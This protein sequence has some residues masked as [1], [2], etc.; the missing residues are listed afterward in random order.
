MFSSARGSGFWPGLWKRWSTWLALLLL[1]YFACNF[2]PI[3]I[4]IPVFG[5]MVVPGTLV[6]CLAIALSLEAFYG[7][8]PRAWALLPAT[9]IVG[10]YLVLAMQWHA[11]GELERTLAAQNSGPTHRFDPATETLVIETWRGDGFW[12]AATE[13][14]QLYQLP[15]AYAHTTSLRP[16]Q[17]GWAQVKLMQLD[18]CPSGFEAL[19]RRWGH[20]FYGIA[21]SAPSCVAQLDSAPVLPNSVTVS[22]ITETQQVW[23]ASVRTVR[24]EV[25]LA[26]GAVFSW[27]SATAQRWQP[28][29][30]LWA[31]I[32]FTSY[33][34]ALVP[35]FQFVSSEITLAERVPPGLRNDAPAAH[36]LGLKRW[37]IYVR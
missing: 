27:T 11:L 6:L 12:D 25:I 33:P 21:R 5:F 9:F 30:F 22:T 10:F 3:L 24:T 34:A 7:Y 2:L 23:G 28:I 4:I 36:L 15:T 31:G 32:G 14:I 18:G 29:P 35:I 26:S 37:A 16:P 1:L 13:Y 19:K 20:E 17:R 8:I